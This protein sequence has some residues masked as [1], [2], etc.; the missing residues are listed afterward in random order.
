MKNSTYNLVMDSSRNPLKNLP[1][2]QRFQIMLMLSIM[3]T[4]IF[5]AAAG[6][7]LYFGELMIGHILFV[8]GTLV[9]TVVFSNAKKSRVE[10]NVG[11]RADNKRTY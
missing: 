10:A 7:W 11:H 5:S 9:T 2:A 6:A 1:I 4:S 8:T 3:W